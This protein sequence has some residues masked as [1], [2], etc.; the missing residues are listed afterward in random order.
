MEIQIVWQ[1]NLQDSNNVCAIIYADQDLCKNL[2][3]LSEHLPLAYDKKKLFV[4]WNVQTLPFGN[5]KLCSSERKMASLIISIIV[6]INCQSGL[7]L[8]EILTEVSLRSNT[9]TLTEVIR[10]YP[11]RVPRMCLRPCE[12]FKI[13]LLFREIFENKQKYIIYCYPFIKFSIFFQILNL[14]KKWIFY[15]NHF[16]NCVFND[17]N[18]YKEVAKGVIEINNNKQILLCAI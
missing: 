7:S 14:F 9:G 8:S 13:L 11:E 15:S 3:K 17:Y 2:A 10:R 1:Q 18:I 12:R 4:N 6:F 5:Q 16:W